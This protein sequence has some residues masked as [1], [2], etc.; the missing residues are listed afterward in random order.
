VGYDKYLRWEAVG[1]FIHLEWPPHFDWF[2]LDLGFNKVLL[3]MLF[4][5]TVFFITQGIL[6]SKKGRFGI[7]RDVLY[8]LLFY[9]FIA[10]LWL[11][12]SVY[13]L[14]TSKDTKWR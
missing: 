1:N 9:A 7:L 5:T 10:P 2:S 14:I 3:Y 8:F 11:A 12:R 6:M 13:N 4:F